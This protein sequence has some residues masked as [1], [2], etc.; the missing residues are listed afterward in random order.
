VLGGYLL[1]T[2]R[3]DLS[4]YIEFHLRTIGCRLCEANLHD[5]REASPPTGESSRRR[6]KF[7]ESSAGKLTRRQ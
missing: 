1:G 3:D 7:F 6:R 5:L 4:D 2:A